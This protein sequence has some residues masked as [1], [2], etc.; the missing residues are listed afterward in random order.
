MKER[1]YDEY[2]TVEP[3]LSEHTYHRA[4]QLENVLVRT[5]IATASVAEYQAR[6]ERLAIRPYVT[7][8]E[9]PVM[10]VIDEQFIHGMHKV[11]FNLYEDLRNE[12]QEALADDLLLQD[13]A[14]RERYG[15]VYQRSPDAP[16]GNRIPQNDT[17]QT[18]DRKA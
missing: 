10:L 4:K 7:P 18:S 14:R 8:A 13:D 2:Y 15:L 1:G 6:G 16:E 17:L 12:S 11:A 9:E 5:T 3:P